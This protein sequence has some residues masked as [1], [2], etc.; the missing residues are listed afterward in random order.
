MIITNNT[1]QKDNISNSSKFSIDSSSFRAFMALSDNLYSQKEFAIVRELISNA[2]D[3]SIAANTNE[4]IKITLNEKLFSIEDFGIGISLDNFINIYSV[5]M[6]STKTDDKNSIGGFGIGGKT[7]FIYTDKFIVETT[8]PETKIRH[9]FTL[10]YNDDFIPS[11]NYNEKDDIYDSVI[12]GTKV[13]FKIKN[14]NDFL[15]FNDVLINNIQLAAINYPILINNKYLYYKNCI[16]ENLNT[17]G[18]TYSDLIYA[19]ENKNFQYKADTNYIRLGQILYKNPISYNEIIEFIRSEKIFDLLQESFSI[20]SILNAIKYY[21]NDSFPK[22]DIFTTFIFS[23]NINGEITL[24]L[25]RENIEDNDDNKNKIKLIIKNS[26]LNLKDKVYNELLK[27]F[28]FNENEINEIHYNYYFFKKIFKYGKFK[29]YNDDF[30]T[31]CFE[32]LKL[33]YNTKIKNIYLNPCINFRSSN[34]KPNFFINEISDV[35]I[36]RDISTNNYNDFYNYK[37]G[38][39][40]DYKKSNI[41]YYFDLIDKIL[42]NFILSNKYINQYSYYRIRNFFNKFLLINVSNP[43]NYINNKKNNIFLN[44]SKE[45]HDTTNYDDNILSIAFLCENHDNTNNNDFEN[46]ILEQKTSIDKKKKEK[47]LN[48]VEKEIL[49]IQ[50]SDIQLSNDAPYERINKNTNYEECV[51]FKDTFLMLPSTFNYYSSDNFGSLIS[52]L[53]YEQNENTCLIKNRYPIKKS[54]VINY[55]LDDIIAFI[56]VEIYD[57]L[58]KNKI[59]PNNI[60]ENMKKILQNNICHL[61]HYYHNYIDSDNF[62][63]KYQSNLHRNLINIDGFEFH[64]SEL[65]DTYTLIKKYDSNK[66]FNNDFI[67]KC[68]YKLYDDFNIFFKK[69]YENKIHNEFLE[70][71]NSSKD[72]LKLDNFNNYITHKNDR[73]NK[74][75]NDMHIY[76]TYHDAVLTIYEMLEYIQSN[77][78]TNDEAGDYLKK[79][80]DIDTDTKYQHKSLPLLNDLLNRMVNDFTYILKNNG[81]D[82]SSNIVNNYYINH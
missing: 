11:I 71:L 29:H 49:N 34:G 10:H 24:D 3:A 56:P 46:F 64:I 60:L 65:D 58:V 2:I 36:I 14:K 30:L 41:N 16:D 66:Y 55:I 82:F 4:P 62:K 5:Y 26:I 54:K 15:F 25:S 51:N 31:K 53:F 52:Y 73:Y 13:S 19:H 42:N 70:F 23:S 63:E 39:I 69:N 8:D 27:I 12:L 81:G 74:T 72:I 17:F 44:Y 48:T 68:M 28:D 80:I 77:K 6:N 32:D 79:Y 75:F 47:K 57:E 22:P 20:L 35:N 76:M 37:L 40:N 18:M 45:I 61:Y 1:K 59:I 33:N 67:V 9:K 43:E 50:L 7:P 78:L 38:D 21:Y